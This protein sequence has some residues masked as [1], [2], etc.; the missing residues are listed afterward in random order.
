[1]MKM[2]GQNKSFEV[3]ALEL[4]SQYAWDYN[5][6]IKTMD[7][8]KSVDMNTLILHRNDFIDLIIYPGKYFGYEGEDRDTIFEVYSHIFRKLYQYTPTRRSGPYQRRAFL[9]R[10]LE[11]AKRRGI[12]VYIENKELYF[13][14]ILLEFYPQLVHQGHICATDPFWLEFLQVK[15]RD[16][17][18][19]FPEIA[20]IIT[21]PATGESRVSL[22][23]NRC[24]CQ[25]CRSTRKEDWFDQVLRAMYAPIHEAGK[26]L[27]V[28][29]FVFDPQAH[30]EIAG[31]MERLPE[32]VVIS[33]KNTP[34]DYYPT[35]P[36]NGRIGR[37]GNHR[38]WIEYDAMGQYFGWGIAMADLT[39][40]YRRRMRYAREKGAGGVVI[41]T[42]WESLDGHTAFGTPNRINLYAGAML[43]RDPDVP[44]QDIYLRFL[45]SEGWLEDGLTPKETERAVRWFAGLMGGT[46]EVTSRMLY[47]QGC[48][49]SDSSLMPVSFAHAFWL[50]EEKNSLKAWDPAKADALAPDREHLEA[51]LAEKQEALERIAALCALSQEPPWGIRPENARGLARRFDIHRE[52]A[53]MYAAAVGALMLTRYV[54]ETGEDRSSEYYR[55]NQAKC[56]LA[57]EA[58]AGWEHRLRRMAAETDYTPHTVY[59]L[60]DGDRMCCLYRDLREEENVENS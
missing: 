35:F 51:A 32:D 55:E 28:R 58:L 37:V 49:F 39:A 1:M 44:D 25:R 48:V 27:V 46:W 30:G 54:R 57:V 5:W 21:A 42:D 31:V 38:Q 7:F 52:F 56:R 47:V 9:K 10:V 16:F 29:D 41:R 19:E 36:D 59:T 18:R 15:Y 34:H 8:M 20:G 12:E 22:N 50:A 11:Q 6:I 13:P 43:A 24:R 3:R 26:T 2:S 40:D 14:D 33:L 23:S 53:E 4:H 45:Q 17:F 60:M